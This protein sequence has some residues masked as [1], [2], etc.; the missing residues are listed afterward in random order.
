MPIDEKKAARDAAMMRARNATQR[1]FRELVPTPRQS[2]DLKAAHDALV[3]CKEAID[4][5]ADALDPHTA[6]EDPAPLGTPDLVAPDDLADEA[7]SS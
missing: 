6:P 7:P 1:L 5:A 4:A 3:E 2:D